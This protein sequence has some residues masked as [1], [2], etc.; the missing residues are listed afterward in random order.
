MP[1][2]TASAT[3]T[4]GAAA[5][6]AE[7][8]EL[9]ILPSAGAVSGRGRLVHPNLGTIDYE[10]APDAWSGIDTDVLMPPTWSSSKTLSGAAHTLWR[11]SLRDGQAI[12]RW[13]AED[14]LAM[15]MS[16][17]RLL[18]AVWQNPVDPALGALQ[19]WPN[20]TTAL[21]YKVALTE[22][23]VGNGQGVTLDYVSRQ[24]WVAAPVALTF[25]ILDRV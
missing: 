6:A 17:L 23:S 1:I 22:L 15:P 18:L 10:Q 4:L 12:E 7:E 8:L 21:G 20:Y 19:W 9:F 14:G 5:P 3:F 13:Q 16:Q 25:R 11:G 2:L 24:G